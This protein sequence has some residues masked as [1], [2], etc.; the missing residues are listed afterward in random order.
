M[1]T[2]WNVGPR[3]GL[4]PVTCFGTQVPMGAWWR[5]RVGSEAQS[6]PC[7]LLTEGN[8]HLACRRNTYMPSVAIRTTRECLVERRKREVLGEYISFVGGGVGMLS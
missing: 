6:K 1:P 3:Y 5:L 8:G 2:G 4:E 7:W